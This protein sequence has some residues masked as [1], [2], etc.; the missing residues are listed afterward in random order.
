[1][2][3]VRRSDDRGHFNHGW[4][5]TY[6][7]FSFADYHDPDH[8]R[9]RSLRVIN[10][11]RVAPGRG[12]GMHP[13]RDMEIITYVLS[14]ELEH[15][16]SMGNR[17]VIKPGEVQYMAAGTG[18]VHG[19]FNPSQTEPVHLMQIWITPNRA[20][21]EPHYEQRPFPAL[22]DAGKLTLLASSDGRAGS[23]SINQDAALYA[24]TLRNGQRVSQAL[25]SGRA[26]WIQVLR[27][28]VEVGGVAL[29]AGDG[30]AVTDEAT[31][32]I[33]ANGDGAEMLVFDLA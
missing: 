8:M 13:H 30:A 2:V 11:D 21:V 16:D 6:H 22:A 9:F 10:E 26:A 3:T 23:I 14:G 17:G 1:M 20:G 15:R 19:E 7:T 18:I 12:F 33:T 29:N 28:G 32:T 27:G 25:E 24:A 31:L 5:D 4:L